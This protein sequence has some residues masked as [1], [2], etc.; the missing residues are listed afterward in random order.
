MKYTY[1]LKRGFTLLEVLIVIGIIAVLSAAVLVA[2]NPT[3]QFKLAR[4]TQRLA[5]VSAIA[6]AISQNMSE[7]KGVFTCDY[8]IANTA[9]PISSA[10]A[11]ILDCLVPTY[12]SALPI[13][14]SDPNARY[15]SATDYNTAYT[16]S[17]N[18]ST[19]RITVAAVGEIETTIEAVR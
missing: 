13:D 2:V 9:E 8:Q 12:I 4:D 6:N 16:V 1:S 10:N 19:S 17:R 15:V 11:D 3:R 18:A 7:H 14:P 5:N